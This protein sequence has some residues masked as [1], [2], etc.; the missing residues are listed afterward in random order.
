MMPR[1]TQQQLQYTTGGRY[2][3][4]VLVAG[5]MTEKAEGK[6]ETLLNKFV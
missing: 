4:P 5:G 6:L 2:Q 1:V 3:L